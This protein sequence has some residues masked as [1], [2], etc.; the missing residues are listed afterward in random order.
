MVASPCSPKWP[1]RAAVFMAALLW[2]K[3]AVMRTSPVCFH[4]TFMG[5]CE[6]HRHSHRFQL[7]NRGMESIIGVRGI[8]PKQRRVN[9]KRLY[10]SLGPEFLCLDGAKLI[11]CSCLHQFL[12]QPP[13]DLQVIWSGQSLCVFSV[14]QCTNVSSS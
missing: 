12:M 5:G 6:A 7:T 14:C 10:S 4:F 2:V 3:E 8:D 13:L 1:T 9:P 11:C